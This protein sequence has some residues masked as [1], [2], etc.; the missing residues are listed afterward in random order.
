M[1]WLIISKLFLLVFGLLFFIKGLTLSR[2]TQKKDEFI[3]Q[4]AVYD[5]S[6]LQTVVIFL[7]SKILKVMPIWVI[8]TLLIIIGI[9]LI[10]VGVFIVP[11]K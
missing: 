6:L 1:V 9:T 7:V 5:A 4:I 2:V 3:D 11:I 8:K 10:Y